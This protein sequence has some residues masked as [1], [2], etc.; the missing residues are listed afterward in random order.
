MS[1]AWHRTKGLAQPGQVYCVDCGLPF[2]HGDTHY[3]EFVCKKCKDSNSDVGLV[4]DRDRGIGS[5]PINLLKQY[6]KEI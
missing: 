5:I 1:T 2:Y 3:T 4:Y 6:N